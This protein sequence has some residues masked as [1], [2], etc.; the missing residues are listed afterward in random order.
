MPITPSGQRLRLYDS[1]ELDCI[2]Q[3]MARQ[4]AALLPPTQA[5]LIGIQRR[6]EPLAQRLGD[7]LWLAPSCSLLHV[8]VDLDSEQKLDAELKFKDGDGPRFQ[9][10]AETTDRIVVV[11]SNGRFYTLVAANLPGGRGMGE[12]VRLMVDLPNDTEIVDLVIHRP[13]EKWLIASSAGDGFILPSDEV[14]AQILQA[15][16]LTAHPDALACPQAPRN[17]NTPTPP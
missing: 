2:L 13:G 7:R 14:V 16:A 3:A 6:G 10:H 12:P 5:V 9:F 8:H 15:R 17:H 11:A 1:D 4:A